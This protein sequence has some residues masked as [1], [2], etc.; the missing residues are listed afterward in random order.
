MELVETEI[1]ISGT[2]SLSYSFKVPDHI[3]IVGTSIL[4]RRSAINSRP[5]CLKSKSSTSHPA[6]QI[7]KQPAD[8]EFIPM[9][10]LAVLQSL[11]TQDFLPS[12]TFQN[13]GVWT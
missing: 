9:N 1:W 13:S 11:G 2:E 4:R 7:P 10:N 3:L 5:K 8:D 6:M 12:G